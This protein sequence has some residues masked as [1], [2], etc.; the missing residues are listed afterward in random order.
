[1]ASHAEL[2][3][4]IESLLP[5]VYWKFDETSGTTFSQTGSSTAAAATPV[6]SV[7]WADKMLIPGDSTGFATFTPG[8]YANAV[9]GDVVVPLTNFSMSCILQYVG[10]AQ[11]QIRML[12]LFSSGESTASNAQL[13][14]RVEP[15]GQNFQDFF[16]YTSSGTNA[17]IISAK[18]LDPRYTIASTPMMFT[19]VRNHSTKQQSFYLNGVLLDTVDYSSAPTGGTS[20]FFSIGNSAALAVPETTQDVSFGHM[21]LFDR[22][23]TDAEIYDMAGYAGLADPIGQL[24]FNSSAPEYLTESALRLNVSKTLLCAID[25]LIDISVAFPDDAYRTEE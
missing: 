8:A 18:V 3:S 24:R 10:P 12:S 6:G 9:K 7:L 23:L 11:T 5:I 4:Y 16:E 14:P 2:T 22:L 13:I 21:C 20:A 17:E 1:M 15:A 25:P 19:T